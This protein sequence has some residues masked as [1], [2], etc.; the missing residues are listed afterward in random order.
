MEQEEHSF[1]KETIKEKPMSMRK[2]L[3]ILAEIIVAGIVFG[4]TACFA[5][6][7]LAPWAQTHFSKEE[8][9]VIQDDDKNPG[10]EEGEG[11]QEMGIPLDFT[12]EDYRQMMKSVADMT[13]DVNRS[14]ATIT[15]SNPTADAEEMLE[16]ASSNSVDGLLVAETR[17][18][19]LFLMPMHQMTG[20]GR[21]TMSFGVGSAC[22]GKIRAY[23]GNTGL[24]ILEVNR[25]DIE[26]YLTSYYRVAELG[27]SYAVEKGSPIIAMGSPFGIENGLALGI[28]SSKNGAADVV[29]ADFTLL[30]SDIVGSP[31]SSGVFVNLQGE[32]LGII[33]PDQGLSGSDVLT[34]ISVSEI[35]DIIEKLSNRSSIP[36]VGIRGVTI[37][38]ATAEANDL[39]EGIYVTAVEM[40]SPAMDAGIQM[41]DIIT[42][43][44]SVPVMTMD[45]FHDV[46]MNT[47]TGKEIR[48]NGKRANPEGWKNF[49]V[50][51]TIG[52]LK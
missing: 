36:Y 8:N 3:T 11:D 15:G 27:N 34:A 21:Y 33:M 45:N 10:T 7:S 46:L 16:A 29:D 37:D 12:A 13:S 50:S 4:V 17:T 25:D 24:G 43:V 9:V 35:K 19:L 18:H 42:E 6:Y 20:Y 40:D 30:V 38:T 44:N 47:S 48:F 41:G 39:E 22:E 14:I 26:G 28:L 52:A 32:V 2:R 23:D 1:I 49:S 5:F 31:R 51:V